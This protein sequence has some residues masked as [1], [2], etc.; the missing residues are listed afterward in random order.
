[1]NIIIKSQKEWNKLPDSFEEFTVIEIRSEETIVI[2]NNPNNSSARLYDNSSARLYGNSSAVLWDNSSARLYGNSSARLYGNSS[3]V[4]AFD[5]SCIWKTTQE[6]GFI[7]KGV[8]IK[9]LNYES[10]FETLLEHNILRADGITREIKSKKKLDNDK[11]LYLLEDDTYCV[12]KGD[13]F[14]H[15]DSSKQALSD[16]NFKLS[17]RDKSQYENLTLDHTFS[18]EDAIV[19]Y[20]TITGACSSGVRDFLKSN[21]VEEKDISINE[22]IK[23]TTDAYMGGVF[24]DFFKGAK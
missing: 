5:S 13:K 7:D 17:D 10:D 20:R 4:K 8:S 21:N 23:L 22:I 24:R 9:A 1:M 14:A 15:G 2:R 3:V 16:L 19:C 12:Q 11:V 18:F 6:V